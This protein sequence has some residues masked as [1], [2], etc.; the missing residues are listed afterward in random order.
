MDGEDDKQFEV[1]C[2]MM[3]EG[4]SGRILISI[5]KAG[6]NIAMKTRCKSPKIDR[7]APEMVEIEG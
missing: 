5:A 1:R 7:G 4:S 3:P 6:R 2:K